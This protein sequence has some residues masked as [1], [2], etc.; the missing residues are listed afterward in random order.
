MMKSLAKK[1]KLSE[2]DA[3]IEVGLSA[4]DIREWGLRGK[5]ETEEEN[6]TEGRA[7]VKEEKKT[8]DDEENN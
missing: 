3:E 4:K 8:N 2:V 5:A 6:E 1:F 7:D